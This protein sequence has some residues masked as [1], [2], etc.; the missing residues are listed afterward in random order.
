MKNKKLKIGF[1]IVL[2]LIIASILYFAFFYQKNKLTS[3]EK[4]WLT[5]NT[6]KVQNVHIINDTNIFGNLGKGVYYD[7]L[8]DLEKEYSIKIN[9]IT[10]KKEEEAKELSLTVG[11]KLKENSFSFYED[12]YVYISKKEESIT[13]Y[14]DIQNKKIGIFTKEAE[15][16]KNYMKELTN[17]FTTFNTVEELITA[18]DTN[19]VTG[20]IV[21][22]ME[23]ID[24]I[25][26]KKYTIAYHF[27]DLKRFFMIEDKTNSTFYQIIKKYYQDWSKENLDKKIK[28][29]ERTLFQEKLSISNTELA[30]LQKSTLVYGYMNN[31]PYEIYGDGSFGG[32]L[33]EYLDSFS[34]F[35]GID[36]EY[37]RYT[38]EKKM[39]KD[40]TNNKINLYWNYLTFATNG[41][42][43]KTNIPLSFDVY[44]H[45][46]NDTVINS[47]A[48]L[49]GK[50]VYV[51]DGTL[52]S[53]SL[54]TI[55]GLVIEKYEPKKIDKILK[56]KD[57]ILIFDHEAG[58]YQKNSLLKKYSVRWT[59]DFE[60]NYPLKSLGNETL[61][62]LLQKYIN[63]LDNHTLLNKGFASASLTEKKGALINS[64]AKYALYGI[65]IIGIILLLIYRSSKKVR[66]QKKLKKE[67]KLKFIDQL[68][69]LKNRN[70][71]NEN[72]AN[73]NKNTIYPQSV[74]IIDLNRIQEINDTA[75]YEEG[76]KQI[77]GAANNLIK[78]QLDNTDIIRTN[79]NEF[80][81][82]LVGYNQKQITSYIHKL[83]KSFKHLPYD[84][85]VC[86][87]YSMILDDLKLI[88]DAINECV[89]EIKKQKESQ[90]GKAK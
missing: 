57:A 73:W 29:K 70:Y 51:E 88:E 2:L 6:S 47:L 17:T 77:K 36:I 78:T 79:G 50:T 9:N 16:I 7:F 13:D 25:L 26:S 74:I 89:E 52:L 43:V 71:L 19:V 22:R 66:M 67:D 45:I 42:N 18:I 10:I 44:M 5:E 63:Y 15:T 69:S 31:L 4:L 87:S 61:N 28:E 39:L 33:H 21:P 75:G 11:N 64:I 20:A 3:E 65:L 53:Q 35:S 49:N 55:E 24:M 38:S 82:Y 32:I 84:Y 46:D 41:T 90:R 81:I 34:N 23:Y 68:T 37:K 12:H 86:I 56:N 85:G 27:S 83:N 14:K 60:S 1:S 59:Y 48:S 54:S 30:N 72:L 58:K 8:S 40:I 62:T 76:D 80:M